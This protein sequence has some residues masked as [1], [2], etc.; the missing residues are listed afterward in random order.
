MN[1]GLVLITPDGQ[2]KQGERRYR[3]HHEAW[4]AGKR[5]VRR[6]APGANFMVQ[7]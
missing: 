6:Q 5:W 7:W 1:Y 4:C 3:T 2:Q